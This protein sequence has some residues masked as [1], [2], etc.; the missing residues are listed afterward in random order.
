MFVNCRL[1]RFDPN[2]YLTLMLKHWEKFSNINDTFKRV[3]G[4][5]VN[6]HIAADIYQHIWIPVENLLQLNLSTHLKTCCN[7]I[8]QHIC[9]PVATEFVNIFENLLKLNF[10]THLKTCCNWICQHIWKPV[11]T[12]F[13]NTFEYLLKLN[14]STHLNTC[15]TEFVSVLSWQETS[16]NIYLFSF[17]HTQDWMF[18]CK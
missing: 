10:S 14:F 16:V 9:K 15:W 3:I 17:S 12:Q 8:C 2:N 4:I 1:L 7:W 13:F 5:L 18:E 6:W 11:E